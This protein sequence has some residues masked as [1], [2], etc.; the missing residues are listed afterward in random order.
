MKTTLPGFSFE[1]QSGLLNRAVRGFYIT[2]GK[3][4]QKQL[5][6]E[7]AYPSFSILLPVN[8]LLP[9]YQKRHRLYDQFLP[10]L[11]KYIEPGTTVFDVGANCGDTLAAMYAANPALSYICVEPDD[12][13]FDLLSTN[14]AR[15][16]NSHA[17]A[18]I[19]LVKCLAGRS[20]TGATLVGEGGTKHA[21]MTGETSSG[22]SAQALDT[23]A[24]QYAASTV[25]LIKSDVDGFDYDVL[26]SAEAVISAE[27]P[28]LFFECQA[29]LPAQQAAYE[30][31]ISRLRNAGY[32]HWVAFDNYGAIVLRTSDISLVSQLFD[33]VQQQNAGRATRTIRYYDLLAYT[34]KDTELLDRVLN[35]Y[36]TL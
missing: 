28:I 30:Q 9:L 4:R 10:H 20:V 35:D 8:H 6:A 1:N 19:A 11:A 7:Y 2:L 36:I 27:S 17:D 22:L 13:F 12:E 23:I 31:T 32:L 29:D 18:S 24:Q 26:D 25:R 15:I 33:Y 16:R 14:T 34:E 3:L 5:V 21:V